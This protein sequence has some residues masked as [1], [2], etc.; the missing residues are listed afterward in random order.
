MKGIAS[1]VDKVIM[2]VLLATFC[3]YSRSDSEFE[4]ICVRMMCT[5]KAVGGCAACPDIHCFAQVF[6][7]QNVYNKGGECKDSMTS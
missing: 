6:V 3:V 2:A 5:C 7:Y 1:D 4:M